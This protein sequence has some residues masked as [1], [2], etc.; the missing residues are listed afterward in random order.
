MIRRPPVS[1]R[2]DTL[3]PYTTLFRSSALRRPTLGQAP[4][5]HPIDLAERREE[6]NRRVGRGDEE[7]GDDIFVLRRHAGATLAAA[8]LG[9]EGVERSA[10]D[11]AVERDGDDHLLEL[12]Q[13]LVIDAVGGRGPDRRAGRARQSGAEGRRGEG[14]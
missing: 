3:L 11:I 14:R 7:F 6:Q 1:T 4:H 12:D 9:A 13:I 10:L 8:A 5:L 2:T